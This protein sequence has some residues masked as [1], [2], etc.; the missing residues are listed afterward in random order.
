MSLDRYLQ[1]PEPIH[2]TEEPRWCDKCEADTW[3]HV[4]AWTRATAE[5]E[6]TECR[7]VTE[8]EDDE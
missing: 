3:H 5:A 7:N 8:I 4:T 1:P 6:C 2:D